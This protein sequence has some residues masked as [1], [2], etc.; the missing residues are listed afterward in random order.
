MGLMPY[1]DIESWSTR[2]EHSGWKQNKNNEREL[3]YATE[4]AGNRSPSRNPARPPR[5]PVMAIVFE[6]QEQEDA[7]LGIEEELLVGAGR[8]RGR[9]AGTAGFIQSSVAPLPGAS[10]ASPIELPDAEV[11]I[12][13]SF[14]QKIDSALRHAAFAAIREALHKVFLRGSDI[15]KTWMELGVRVGSEARASLLDQASHSLELLALSMCSTAD[16]YECRT[17][18]ESRRRWMKRNGKTLG[19][20]WLY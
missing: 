4:G 15:D 1:A 10:S 18:I 20:S 13:V 6:A 14:S 8:R 16:G 5:H 3:F 19:R 17:E 11:A 2:I 7:R 9:V 12:D